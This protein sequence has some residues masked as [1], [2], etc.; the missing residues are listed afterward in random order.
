MRQSVMAMLEMTDW[1]TG[2]TGHRLLSAYRIITPDCDY[3]D[4]AL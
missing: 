2:S 4:A 1:Q 3:R